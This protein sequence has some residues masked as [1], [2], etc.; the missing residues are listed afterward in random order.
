[1]S[2]PHLADLAAQ[3][4]ALTACGVIFWRTEPVLNRMSRCTF[5]LVWLAFFLLVA[6]SFGG[7]CWILTGYVP[8]WPTVVLIAGVAL[9]LLCERRVRVFAR[10][11]RMAGGEGVK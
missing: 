3:T 9:L 1:M 8:A 7:I 10:G 11:A 4:V 2:A 5:R 6:G